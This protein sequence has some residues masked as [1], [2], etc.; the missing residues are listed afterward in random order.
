MPISRSIAFDRESGDIYRQEN[1]KPSAFSTLYKNGGDNHIQQ[2][3]Q[4]IVTAAQEI[5][6]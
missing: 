3:K 5:S 6:A 1:L 4:L 2:G